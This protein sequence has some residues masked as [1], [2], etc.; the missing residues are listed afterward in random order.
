M[1]KRVPVGGGIRRLLSSNHVAEGALLVIRPYEM[2]AGGLHLACAHVIPVGFD[3][4]DLHTLVGK[5]SCVVVG[6]DGERDR[7]RL[8]LREVMK[9]QRCLM[10][11]DDLGIALL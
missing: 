5:R 1:P 4:V 3:V 9:P 10:R 8:A 2:A 11:E 6:I 7:E